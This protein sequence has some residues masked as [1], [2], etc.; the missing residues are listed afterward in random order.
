[1]LQGE[2]IRYWGFVIEKRRTAERWEGVTTADRGN[3][4]YLV[5]SGLIMR[6]LRDEGVDV[7]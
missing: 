3:E 7:A 4:R 6:R 2:G 5:L 1:M